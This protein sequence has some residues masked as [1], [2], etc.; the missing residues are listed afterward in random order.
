VTRTIAIVLLLGVACRGGDDHAPVR[1]DASGTGGPS[2]T[3]G[4]AASDTQSLA[5]ATS[6][7][8]P[9]TATALPTEDTGADTGEPRPTAGAWDLDADGEP[10]SELSIGVCTS[11]ASA[12]CL[13]IDSP[14]TDA[15]EVFL[16]AGTPAC[17]GN[18]HGAAIALLG[19]HD[20][21]AL[22]EIAAAACR[23]DSVDAPPAVAVVDPDAGVVLAWASAPALHVNAW[24]AAPAAPDG[25]R[26]PVLAPSYGEGEN[27]DGDWLR[28]CAYRPD[29]PEDPACGPGFASFLL[30][31]PAPAF[32]VVGGT[33]FDLDGDGWEDLSFSFHRT[34]HTASIG[35]MSDLVATTFDVAAV[36]EPTSPPWFHSGRNYGT[37][38]AFGSADGLARLLLVG[39]TPI[40]S[41]TDDLCNVS[42]FVAVLDAT[43]GQPATR[44]LAWSRYYGFSS[45]IFST[46]SPAFVG[47]PA[48]DVARLADVVDG[49]IHRF[50]DS[51]S[52]MDGE[53]VLVL[54]VFTMDAPIDLCLDEQYDLYQEPAWTPEKADAWYECFG[55]NVAAP[56]VW[57]QHVLREG[58]GSPLTGSQETYVWG[59]TDALVP[60]DE[61]VYLVEV[62]PGSGAFDL[63]D[64]TPGTIEA[65][66]LVDGLWSARGSFPDAGRPRVLA[67]PAE[68]SRGVGSYTPFAELSLADRDGDGL[69]EVEREDGTFVGWDA[70]TGTFVGKP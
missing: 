55:Q 27:P 23:N 49:C 7:S 68:G 25:L 9:A 48:A 46:Y 37:H 20:G 33:L 21:G 34:I 57:G 47:D 29:L 3:T 22:Q 4:G 1:D 36:D 41:F 52:R 43:P 63:S 45:T 40:G 6:E 31:P 44:H 19:D 32:R 56:G 30:S 61:V 54:N 65:R 16:W 11:D 51:R 15:R 26:H 35:T 12:T 58:D 53:D 62:L 42:R 38:R 13:A 2:G 66:A 59:W 69:V 17:T 10:E 50:S 39:G 64:R 70:A 8:D 24:I 67:V 5:D 60:G 18:L 28:P 14:L